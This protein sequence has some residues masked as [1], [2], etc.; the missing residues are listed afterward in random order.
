MTAGLAR[1]AAALA[2]LAGLLSLPATAGAYVLPGPHLIELMT[3]ALGRAPAVR[4]D[5]QV[6]VYAPGQTAP[7]CEATETLYFNFHG[8]FRSD[9]RSGGSR[10]IHVTAGDRVLT[11]IDGRAAADR[12][13]LFE[14]Y[15]DLFM[16]RARVLVQDRLAGLGVD[17]NTSSL[18]RLSDQIVFVL[19]AHYPDMSASQV[20]IDR[21]HFRPVRW[22]VSTASG[23]LLDIR[24]LQWQKTGRF[25][26]P[27]RMLFYRKDTL[28]REHRVTAVKVLK[29]VPKGLFNLRRL[30]Q[31]H[32]AP[33]DSPAGT[34]ALP[35]DLERA[36]EYFNQV[37]R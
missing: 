1:A 12:E 6:T 20:W 27:S 15:K 4:I 23:D 3:R 28:V 26:Y 30:V 34:P 22:L 37:F 24:Y 36:V 29:T 14:R 8:D 33:A 31:K 7:L 11:V 18:G 35:G 16:Y 25:W 32:L 13:T 19:G 21:E 17:V 10:R 5:Q 9:L 2:L